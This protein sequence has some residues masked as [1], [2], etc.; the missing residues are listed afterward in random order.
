MA[1]K[2]SPVATLPIQSMPK[3]RLADRFL[4]LFTEVRSGEGIGA[5]LLA[6]NVLV[7]SEPAEVIKLWDGKPPGEKGE[8]GQEQDTTKPSDHSVAGKRVI[9]LGNVSQPT[10][11]IY[12]PTA[13][14]ANGA[15]TTP[16]CA[17]A[18]MNASMSSTPWR[19]CSASSP[20]IL[21]P[22]ATLGS[23][24]TRSLCPRCG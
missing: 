4:S 9:R 10:I 21:K 7:A 15:A 12:R 18:C 2:T 13:A 22:Q 6:A 17:P 8:I 23:S 24:T 16:R 11:S 3:R 14:K 5:L 20:A 19:P 1:S